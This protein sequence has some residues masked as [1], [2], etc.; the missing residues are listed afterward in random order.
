[1]IIQYTCINDTS[2]IQRFIRDLKEALKKAKRTG[3]GYSAFLHNDDGDA[4]FQLEIAPTV[5]R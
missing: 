3:G 5:R 1:M 4:I 2:E